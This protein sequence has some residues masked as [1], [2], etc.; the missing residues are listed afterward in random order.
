M[1]QD[2]MIDSRQETISVLETIDSRLRWLS[3]W[4]VHHA[5]HIRPKRD[6]LKVGGH[7]ASCASMTA[8]MTALYFYA[9]RPQDKVSVKPHAGPVLQALNPLTTGQLSFTLLLFG[10]SGVVG[11]F[12]GG[13]AADKFGPLPTLRV[14]LTVLIAMMVLVPFTA[15]HYALCVAVFVVWGVAGFGMMVPQQSRLASLA[16]S[17]APLLLS[18]NGSMLYLGTAL[19][20]A[21]SGAFIN[22]L[23]FAQLAWVG[24]PFGLAAAATLWWDARADGVLSAHP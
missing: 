7:Q 21:I 9:L 15:G 22:S 16:P 5:N 17:Q 10:L 18:L 12:V 11:T 20:A 19:G 23:G 6:G 24:V 14:Q 2:T 3:S 13:W 1:K 8:I 4:T